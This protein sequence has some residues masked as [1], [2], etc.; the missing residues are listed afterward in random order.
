MGVSGRGAQLDLR[1]SLLGEAILHGLG[2]IATVQRVVYWEPDWV[3]SPKKCLKRALLRQ[4]VLDWM[5]IIERFPSVVL[6][7]KSDKRLARGDQK[8][9]DILLS[10]DRESQS[11]F[12]TIHRCGGETLFF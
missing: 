5:L 7:T 6:S 11:T 8:W 9:P 12:P 2:W 4:N 3:F 1:V 10:S